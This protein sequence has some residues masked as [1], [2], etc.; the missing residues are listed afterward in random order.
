MDLK[1]DFKE[2]H[3]DTRV[4]IF[5][6]LVFVAVLL[7][8]SLLFIYPVYSKAFRLDD[9][10]AAAKADLVRQR[11]FLPEYVRLKELAESADRDLPPVPRAEPLSMAQVEG[12][13]AAIK[14]LAANAG[15]EPLDVIISPGSLKQ[16]E[17]RIMM[18][19]ILA[20]DVGAFEDFFVAL[21]GYPH[22]Y[23]VDRLEMQAVPGGVEIFVEL[24]I[25]LSPDS[26][27][28]KNGSKG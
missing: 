16:G 6:A 14:T 27:S 23:A 2:L 26:G 28:G 1:M 5:K 7:V 22:L 12:L 17:P 24:W 19:C 4:L 8:A 10:I 15:L 13:P 21:N 20:G 11:I 9:E 3:K 18:Q 25:A